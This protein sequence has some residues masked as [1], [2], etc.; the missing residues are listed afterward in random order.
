MNAARFLRH[1]RLFPAIIVVG[2][3]LLVLKGIGI[4]RDAQAQTAMTGQVSVPQQETQV[5]VADPSDDDADSSSAAEVDVLTSL[6]KR[7]AELDAR[8]E[9]LDMQANLIAAAEK[10]VDDKIASLRDMQAQMQALLGQRDA[11][12]QAQILSLVKTY[13]SM[14]PADAARIFDQLDETVELNVAALMKADVLGAI[15]AKMQ[16]DLAQKLTVRLANRLKLPDPA[17][18]APVASAVPATAP[19]QTAALNPAAATPTPMTPAPSA[20]TTPAANPNPAPAPTTPPKPAAQVPPTGKPQTA[21]TSA[22]PAMSPVPASTPATTP[23]AQPTSV[24]PKPQ[25]AAMTPPPVAAGAAA[26]A[27]NPKG[28]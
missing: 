25:A 10:R 23:K 27:P 8:E 18:A 3:G 5:A 24:A 15:L 7:R 2:G 17:S 20:P 22:P 4:V 13:S 26:P 11:A 1:L 21:A 9:S 14:K 19:A 6:S 28:G 16:P 12:E